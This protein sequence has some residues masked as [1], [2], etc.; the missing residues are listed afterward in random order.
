M[1]EGDILETA[2]DRSSL[3]HTRWQ[4]E[5]ADDK[6][7][8]YKVIADSLVKCVG[9]RGR[10]TVRDLQDAFDHGVLRMVSTTTLDGALRQAYQPT[11]MMYG[12]IPPITGPEA[13]GQPTPTPVAK[14]SGMACKK[15]K[16]F[17]SYAEANQPDGTLICYSCRQTH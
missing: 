12:Y 13:N 2:V 7:V 11:D 9:I 15:C 14:S 1:K 6:E 5:W 3:A 17:Y 8:R 4:I 10:D 16:E